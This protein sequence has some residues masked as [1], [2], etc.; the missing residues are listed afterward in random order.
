MGNWADPSVW[1]R[2]HWLAWPLAAGLVASTARPLRPSPV[3]FIGDGPAEDFGPWHKFQRAAHQY[4]PQLVREASVVYLTCPKRDTPAKRAAIAAAVRRGPSVLV[5]PTGN[6]AV[7][8]VAESGRTPV[9]FASFLDPI[10]AGFAASDRIPGARATGVSLADW[11]DAK[12]LQ[13]LR[14]AFPGIRRV[15][16]LTDRSWAEHYQ[17]EARVLADARALGLEATLYYGNTAADIDRLMSQP[18]A[19]LEHAWYAM[20]TNLAYVGE[21]RILAHLKRLGAPGMFSTVE[22]VQRGGALAYVADASFVYPKLAELVARVVNGEDPGRI[23][24]ERPRRFLLAARADAQ[25]NGQP[26]SARVLRR[27]DRVV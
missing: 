5:A 17:G 19:A 9:V 6:S 15:G 7:L 23:P 20:P 16:V 22:E 10:R 14:D 2:R 13:T 1:R 18:S 21:A 27:A 24:I 8:A 25:W 11:L 12:R 26:I 4:Q 3:V